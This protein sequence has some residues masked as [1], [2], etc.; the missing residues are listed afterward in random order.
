MFDP[1][2]SLLVQLMS[3]AWISLVLVPPVELEV[4]SGIWENPVVGSA[5]VNSY[6]QSE[7]PY[8][9]GH[10]GVDFAVSLGQGVFAPANGTVHYV[11]KVVDRQ[12]ISIRHEGNLISAFEPVCSVLSVGT[13]VFTG[14][15][16]GEVCEADQDY[17]PHCPDQFC[18]HFSARKS[19]EYLSPLWLT[20]D[21]APARLLPWIEP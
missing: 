8:S 2:K 3:F 11:G 18:L 4:A 10:R 5:L 12:L 7:T 19:D 1:D 9:S 6:R 14:E 16:I 13:Q 17:V 15:L 20:G 21:L